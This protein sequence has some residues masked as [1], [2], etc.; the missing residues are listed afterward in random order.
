VV[1]NRFDFSVYLNG[2]NVAH[3]DRFALPNGGQTKIWLGWRPF[4][5]YGQADYYDLRL[6]RTALPDDT[7]KTIYET[8]RPR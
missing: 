5:R 6:F 3:E 1:W 7:V 8:S 2:E 4:N